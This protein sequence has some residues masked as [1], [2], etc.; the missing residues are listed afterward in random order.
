MADEQALTEIMKILRE[1]NEKIDNVSTR[2]RQLEYK[3]ES[4]QAQLRINQNI[5]AMTQGQQLAV[6]YEA[7]RFNSQI[8]ETISPAQIKLLRA[9]ALADSQGEAL[10]V[11]QLRDKLNISRTYVHTLLE[12][13]EKIGM[14]RRIPNLNNIQANTEAQSSQKPITP[15]HLY[16]INPSC[17]FPNE[18]R[19]MVPEL[20][21]INDNNTK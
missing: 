5:Q 4:Q 16:T 6:D 9:L 17:S 11:Y 20:K 21:N 18:L 7:S 3:Q 2:L 1:L 12:Q 19:E 10:T 14:V 13:L 15:R 8:I